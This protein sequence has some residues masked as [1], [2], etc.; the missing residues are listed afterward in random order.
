MSKAYQ[1]PTT[2]KHRKFNV[3]VSC[4]MEL[5]NPDW[6]PSEE[7]LQY[8]EE[9]SF[10]IEYFYDKEYDEYCWRYVAGH[11]GAKSEWKTLRLK[12]SAHKDLWND[13]RDRLSD[14]DSDGDD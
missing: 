13:L 10:D 9:P 5:V 6:K 8:T 12:D 1:E 14:E 3:F 7:F 2:I 11:D 4:W